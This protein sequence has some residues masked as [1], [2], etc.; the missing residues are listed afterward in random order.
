VKPLLRNWETCGVVVKH[1][2]INRGLV[3]QRVLAR[4]VLGSI[5]PIVYGDGKKTEEQAIAENFEWLYNHAVERRKTARRGQ[6]P[7]RGWL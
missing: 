7:N 4:A 3:L 2:L 1:G 6:R 5:K